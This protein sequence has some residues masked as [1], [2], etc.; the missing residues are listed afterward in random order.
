MTANV[1]APT[2]T[3]FDF[4]CKLVLQRSA[5]VLESNKAYL[6]ESRLTPVVQQH[7]LASIDD[8]V[9]KLRCSNDSPLHKD[10][11][12]A[13]TTNETSFFRDAHPFDGLR[14]VI[15]PEM[16][17]KRAARKSINIWCAAASTGQEPYTICMVLRE[18][19]PALK[20]WSIRFLAS[21]LSRQVLKRAKEGLFNQC[22]VNRGL[23]ATLLVKYFTKKGLQWQIKDEIRSM[24]QFVELNLKDP[25]PALPAD[26]DLVFMRNVLI[27]FSAET[28]KEILAKTRRVLAP[29]G[30]LFLGGA[31][32]TL[33]LDDSYQR[34]QADKAVFYQRRSGVRTP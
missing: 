20:D 28:K 3:S 11:V 13:L 21:D 17:I 9:A 27:Y 31:E 8:L 34:V 23:P 5:I 22:E 1:L 14:K 24:V 19:F 29:D 7:G 2:D 32:T 12:D 4:V 16:I 15:I 33:N 26:M 18:Y 10:V 30:Y 6:V 25:W